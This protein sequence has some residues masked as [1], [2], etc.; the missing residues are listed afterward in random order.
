MKTQFLTLA[1]LTCAAI[2]LADPAENA[3]NLLER[4]DINRGLCAVIGGEAEFPIL[5]AKASELLVHYRDPDL[6]RVNAARLAADEA[7]LGLQ[8][9]AA[10]QGGTSILPYATNTV[11]IVVCRSE[12]LNEEVMRV[13]RPKGIA[14]TE[15][16]RSWIVQEKP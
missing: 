10:E 3:Y 16:G 13:L 4:A 12:T 15:D 5:L 9:L 7:N 6:A 14:F 2:A 1:A 8:R 11:D